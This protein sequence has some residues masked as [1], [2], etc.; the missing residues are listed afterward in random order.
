MH[1]VER[2]VHRFAVDWWDGGV[3]EALHKLINGGGRHG[4]G[5]ELINN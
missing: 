2:G 1:S 5:E 4:G 3:F